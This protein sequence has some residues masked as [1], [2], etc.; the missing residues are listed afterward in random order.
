LLRFI[1]RR[2]WLR[3]GGLGGLGL[4]LPPVLARSRADLPGFGKARSVLIIHA[5]GGQS[6]IDTWDPKPDAPAEVRGEC[7]AKRF[8]LDG[9]LAGAADGLHPRGL[10]FAF[11]VVMSA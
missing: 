4:V 9:L 1:T 7:G 5:S 6:R 11:P 2:E 8:R 10:C 3:I